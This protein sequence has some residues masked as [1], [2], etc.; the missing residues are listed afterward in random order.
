LACCWEPLFAAGLLLRFSV[1]L[2]EHF[3]DAAFVRQV[4]AV[5][6][7]LTQAVSSSGDSGDSSA[8][9]WCVV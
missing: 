1:A 7:E 5:G 2:D 6:R 9:C 3:V 8:A 4:R